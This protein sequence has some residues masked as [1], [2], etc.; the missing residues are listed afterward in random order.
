MPRRRAKSIVIVLAVA[1][2]LLVALAYSSASLTARTFFQI[3]R[4]WADHWPIVSQQDALQALEPGLIKMRLLRPVRVEAEPGISF[5]LDPRDLIPID[6]LRTG[7]WQPEIWSSIA[8][9]LSEGSVFFDV[10]A[11]IGYFSM[12]ASR[13]V[14]PSG[15]VLSFEPNPETLKLLRDNV[16]ANHT[17]NVT[18]EPIACT[19]REQMLTLYAADIINTGASS[20][21]SA[22]ASITA[23]APKA[24]AVRGRPIDDVVRE[25]SLSRVDVIKVDVEGAEVSVMRGALETLRRFHPKVVIEVSPRQLASFHTTPDDL[26]ALFQGAGYN[27]R[28]PLNREQA[29][30]EWTL[31]KPGDLASF[32]A[33]DNPAVS[34]QL[35]RG[36]HSFGDAAHWTDQHFT[37]ALRTPEGSAKTGA[38]LSLKLFVASDSIQA[39]HEI[40]LAASAGGVPLQPET[41]RKTGVFEYRREVPAAALQRSVTE[42]DFSVDKFLTRNDIE[43]GILVMSVAL[44]PR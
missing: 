7:Q 5:F 12:K 3:E 29:D 16:A 1:L 27:L 35:V 33:V 21:S 40:T 43:Y 13:K 44:E 36:V 24:Y 32:V 10:G 39:F 20:L 8:P 4:T 26:I 18:V 34:A 38:W 28:R 19:D 11:H 9:S 42:I 22:N 6:I 14:G 30:W 37:V 31:V 41:F 17:A 23:A 15:R 2:G 25:L